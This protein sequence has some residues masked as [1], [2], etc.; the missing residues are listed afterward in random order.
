MTTGLILAPRN[1]ATGLLDPNYYPVNPDNRW[2]TAS[3]YQLDQKYPLVAAYPLTSAADPMARCF[4]ANT[5]YD[6]SI[7]FETAFGQPPF[8]DTLISS[9]AS[10]Y[11]GSGGKTQEFTRTAV[12]GLSGYYKYT[13][14]SN[15]GKL[16]W[17][18]AT[19]GEVGNFVFRRE[20]SAGDTF[21]FFLTVTC[22]DTKW[23]FGD[24]SAPDETGDGSFA[25]PSKTYA[26]FHNL[27]SANNFLF[28][29]AAGDY[30]IHNGT[31]G[32]NASITSTNGATYILEDG[33]NFVCDDG[34]FTG[35]RDDMYFDGVNF[36]G[37]RAATANVKLMQ[38]T[39]RT[40]RTTYIDCSGQ[41]IPT[42]DI[43]T[44]DNPAMIAFWSVGGATPHT[45]IV[46]RNC[47]IDSSCLSPMLITFTCSNVT[48]N[49][50]VGDALDMPPQNISGTDR[51]VGMFINFKDATSNICTRFC[52]VDGVTNNGF[53]NYANQTSQYADK[54]VFEYNYLDYTGNSSFAP[55]IWNQNGG[56]PN[57]K[58]TNQF[59]QKNT[60]IG[61]TTVPVASFSNGVGG[62]KM[63]AA[64]TI[65]KS[66]NVNFY[67]NTAGGEDFGTTNV[68]VT[69]LNPD[70]SLDAA[71]LAANAGFRGHEIISTLVT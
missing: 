65:W 52:T 45:D 10:A 67:S 23:K 68:K 69:A 16:T 29:F 37:G 22:D 19:Q 70:G 5:H 47:S 11:L 40:H 41:D 20:D 60:I 26:Q 35:G 6:Y 71:D 43:S 34:H 39:T 2:K 32:N 46:M 36:K 56:A 27:A 44:Q 62:E 9:P 17:P 18:N 15:F 12:A 8:R 38:W 63:K 7:Y 49:N 13:Q 59:A 58:G 28:H 30:A 25:D 3:I 50:C 64:G 33:A 53:F 1:P 61:G 31:P 54:Q 57:Y 51:Y 4:W 55:L 21:L 14:P 48:V 24:A 42:G 66:T